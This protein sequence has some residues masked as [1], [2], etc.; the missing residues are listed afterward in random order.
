MAK[1]YKLSPEADK[2]IEAIFDYAELEYG[3]QKAADYTL[4]FSTVFHKIT[5]DPESGRAR[6]EIK[7]GLRS[8]VQNKHVVFYRVLKGHIH[9]VRILHCR[10]DVP[11]F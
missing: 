1:P 11:G 10:S 6:S 3:L 2:D 4:Q 8:L 7:I 9:I 5:Q